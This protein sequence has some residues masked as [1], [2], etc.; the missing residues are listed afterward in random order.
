MV[1]KNCNFSSFYMTSFLPHFTPICQWY[2]CFLLQPVQQVFV[3]SP[4][5]SPCGQP[6]PTGIQQVSIPLYG[7][8]DGL[9]DPQVDIELVL[10]LRIMRSG[11]TSE[12]PLTI[13][14]ASV[15]DIRNPDIPYC[16][17]VFGA[18]VVSFDKEWVDNFYR[19]F[20][21]FFLIFFKLY[22]LPVTSC[23]A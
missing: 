4:M 3:P 14:K 10:I 18:F 19:N 8:V 11:I 2:W 15:Q 13:V 5:S 9:L 1:K 16:A 21:L 20:Y 23:S 12:R 22:V 6:L 7:T 17:L